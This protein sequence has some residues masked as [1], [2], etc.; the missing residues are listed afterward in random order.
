MKRVATLCVAAFLL[1]SCGGEPTVRED[2]MVSIGAHQLHIVCDGSGAPSVVLDSSLGQ[3]AADWWP[4][5]ERLSPHTRV[6][7][8]DRAGYGQSDPGPFPRD[9]R[10]VARKFR[11][12]VEAA[13]AV[14]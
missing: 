7:A 5:V 8:Y 6:C 2:R 9:S 4:I 13:G 11:A 10:T 3:S 12:L 14:R 1:S